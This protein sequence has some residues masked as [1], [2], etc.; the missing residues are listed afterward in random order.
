VKEIRFSTRAISYH[1]A[2]ALGSE[3]ER[4]FS[5][6]FSYPEAAYRSAEG[7]SKARRA[8]RPTIAFVCFALLVVI[9]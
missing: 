9:P 1:Y 2:F 5:P 6:A 4:G 7:R 8:K 3:V